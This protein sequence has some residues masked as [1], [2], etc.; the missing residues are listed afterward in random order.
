MTSDTS[1]K[2]ESYLRLVESRR[3][4]W[5][6]GLMIT[7]FLLIFVPLAVLGSALDWPNNLAEDAAY[8]LPLLIE[9]KNAAFWGYFIYLLYS[10]LFFP[11]GHMMGKCLALDSSTAPS[12][13][14]AQPDS[15]FLSIGSG[16][17]AL[18]TVARCIGLSRW[19]FAMPILAEIYVDPS[20]TNTTKEAV[21][22]SYEVLNGWGGG[23]GEILGVSMFA[24]LWVCC[25]SVLYLQSHKY[26]SWMGW[27]GFVVAADLA[28]NLLEMAILGID[29]GINL[30]ISVVLLH[31]WILM[32]ALLFM[33]LPFL[34]CLMCPSK[35]NAGTTNEDMDGNLEV[36]QDG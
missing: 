30:T 5:T 24:A 13:P 25:M 32:A 14:Y 28:V 31:L 18:S 12:M 3:R 8:N 7:F 15:P 33:E 11:M 26:P 9:E 29:M 2:H 22:V 17:A 21:S 34:R 10:M 27:V 36:A 16:F 19:L 23:I 1:A 6:I 35:T 4:K 20:T